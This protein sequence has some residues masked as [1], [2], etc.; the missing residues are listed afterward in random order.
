MTW[1]TT[2]PQRSQVPQAPQASA[3]DARLS[4]LKLLASLAVVVVHTSMARVATMDVHSPSWWWANMADAAGHLGSATFAMVAG[5]VLLARPIEQEPWQ[6]IAGRMRRLLPAVLFWSAVYFFWRACNGEVMTASSMMRDVLL[7][8]PMYH[9]WFLFMLLAA[10][11]VLPAL[12]YGVLG[13]E[14]QRDPQK[15]WRYVLAVLALMTWVVSACQALRQVWHTSFVELV[16]LFV[17]YLLAGY[18]FL[19]YRVA[20]P[21]WV[22]CAAGV[23]CILLMGLG[24]GYASSWLSAWAQVLFYS[25][26]GPFAMILTFCV[27]LLAMRVP[28]GRVPSWVQRLGMVT[29]GVYAMHPLVMAVLAHAGWRLDVATGYNW[30]WQ[31]LVVYALSMGMSAALH[32][33]PGVRRLVS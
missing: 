14:Q 33:V 15:C 11:W 20:V 9:L 19:R 3:H 29:L 31:A 26:R 2:M 8:M 18:Y 12:R 10:Y 25:N 16:P 21:T 7:G 17:V 22:L 13:L 24:V 27:F 23:L 1:A 4:L 5:A 28:A 30:M 32:M 6:F